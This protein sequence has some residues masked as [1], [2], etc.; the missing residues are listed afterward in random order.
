MLF[1]VICSVIDVTGG[2][3]GGHGDPVAPTY[4]QRLPG[5]HQLT[6]SASWKAKAVMWL[7]KM[8]QDKKIGI[9][10]E[11]ADLI[12]QLKDYRFFPSAHSDIT[13]Y[14]PSKGGHDDLVACALMASWAVNPNVNW[15]GG[16][17]IS[18]APG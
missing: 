17:F 9:P 3:A 16:Q 4:A 18:L 6:W 7:D 14:G 13:H 12:H 1:R 5:A 11:P 15:A 10:A 8:M 2:G